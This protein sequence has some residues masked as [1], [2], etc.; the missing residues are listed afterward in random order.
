MDHDFFKLNPNCTI[1]NPKMIIPIALIKLKTKVE[2]LL[3]TVNGSPS[4]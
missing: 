2:R 1:P 4:A 3:T